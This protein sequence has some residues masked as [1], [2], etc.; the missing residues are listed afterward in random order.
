MCEFP[1][2]IMTVAFEKYGLIPFA[3]LEDWQLRRIT[4]PDVNIT[5]VEEIEK[6]FVI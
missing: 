4:G 3:T 6:E 5:E 2:D 1:T